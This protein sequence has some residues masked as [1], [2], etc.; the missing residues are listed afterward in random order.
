MARY[1]KS[2]GS[3]RISRDTSMALG[4]LW[5]RVLAGL[6]IAS[7]GYAKVFGGTV[8]RLAQNLSYFAGPLPLN[9]LAWAAAL[10][11][12]AG[13]VLMA[14]GLVTRGAAL[15][16]FLVMSVAA[17]VH[18]AGDS[19]AVKELALAYWT[20]AGAIMWIGPGPVSLDHFL[21]GGK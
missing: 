8:D 11:E 6:G 2:G 18:H 5:L 21:K 9:Y 13:G 4:L 1:S 14:I 15:L 10:S 16:I 3:M 12:L 19:F 20:V 7:H 17:F